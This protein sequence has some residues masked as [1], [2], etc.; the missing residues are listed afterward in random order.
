MS[1]RRVNVEGVSRLPAFSQAVVAG[2]HIYVAGTLGT[3]ENEMRLVDGGVKAETVQAL[4]NIERILAGAGA[5]LADVVK[6]NVY[7]TDMDAFGE[8]NEAYTEFFGDEPPAR[9]TVGCSALAL[10]AAVEL[11]CV[12]F[13]A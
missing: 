5:T 3:V 10:G 11:D 12:A 4:R 1:V 7:I 13:H 9:I 6:V 8:M 2:D